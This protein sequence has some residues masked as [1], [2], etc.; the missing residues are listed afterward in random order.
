MPE[1]TLRRARGSRRWSALLAVTGALLGVALVA[2]PAAHAAPATTGVLTITADA[3]ATAGDTVTVAIA[4]DATADLFAY[5]VV[6]SY[7]PALLSYDA[8]S[9]VTP[10]GGFAAASADAGAVT[11]THTRL[12]TSPGLTGAQTL[13][14]VT[15]TTLAAGDARIA[16]TGGTLIGTEGESTPIDT[17]GL[18]AMTT[19]AAA[20]VVPGTPTEPSPGASPDPGTA[21]PVTDRTPTDPLAVTGADATG[22][23]VTGAVAAALVALGA[24]LV[25][26]RRAATR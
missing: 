14:T 1:S 17:T 24:V 7:D 11:L 8:D 22:W 21:L 13:A 23:L 15:F 2:A 3:T 10:D 19:I 6:V 26:R 12:G 18:E 4:A 5:D 16:V 20:P 9:L 25:I